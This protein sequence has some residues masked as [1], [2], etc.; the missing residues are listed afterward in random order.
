MLSMHITRSLYTQICLISK[1]FVIEEMLSLI[2]NYQHSINNYY[3]K[4]YF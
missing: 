2:D 1:D 4:C 3:F